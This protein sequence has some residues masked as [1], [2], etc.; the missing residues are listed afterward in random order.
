MVSGIDSVNGSNYS[1]QIKFNNST[2]TSVLSGSLDNFDNEDHAIISAQ[3]K[4]LNEMEKYNS[5]QGNEVDLAVIRIKSE[6]QV[7]AEV[8]LINTKKEMLDSILQICKD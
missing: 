1:P 3:A 2:N 6:T 5:G 8:N 4:L 7:K